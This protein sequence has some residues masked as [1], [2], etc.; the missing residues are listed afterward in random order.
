MIKIPIIKPIC[1]TNRHWHTCSSDVGRGR[2][3]HFSISNWMSLWTTS[4][5]QCFNHSQGYTNLYAIRKFFFGAKQGQTIWADFILRKFRVFF[6]PLQ[7][8]NKPTS[9]KH[10]LGI[11]PCF[12]SQVNIKQTRDMENKNI[13]KRVI[14]WSLP[15]SL[16]L[17]HKNCWT[18][19]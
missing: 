10:S 13:N 18:E 17:H 2:D 14:S 12:M 9:L 1:K 4:F 16:N 19:S 11:A 3:W 8:T 5:Q 7:H 6:R 15:N